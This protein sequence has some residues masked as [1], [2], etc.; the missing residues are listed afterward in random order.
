MRP[1]ARLCRI[2]TEYLHAS[3][4]TSICCFNKKTVNFPFISAPS[5]AHGSHRR[6]ESMSQCGWG[7]EEVIYDFKNSVHEKIRLA[8]CDFLIK[9]GKQ[10]TR[11]KLTALKQIHKNRTRQCNQ[12]WCTVTIRHSVA[13]AKII[14]QEV[15]GFC[16]FPRESLLIHENCLKSWQNQNT[17][18]I[19]TSFPRNR[20][21]AFALQKHIC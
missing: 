10:D 2:L 6:H 16:Q 21:T 17:C 11:I 3:V 8:K 18:Q 9:N 1:T 19:E 5:E 12:T 13:E 15:W 4:T 20:F 14:E 7:L